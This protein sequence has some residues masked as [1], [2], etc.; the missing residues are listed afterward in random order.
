M[1]KSLIG[2]SAFA[3]VALAVPANSASADD[4]SPP[5]V[6]LE[7]LARYVP[8]TTMNTIY[9]ACG[10]NE[11][12]TTES[13][14]WRASDASGMCSETFTAQ[15][16]ETLGGDYDP[17]LGGDTVTYSVSPNARSQRILVDNFDAG[18][19]PNRFV[20][21]VT[22]C[23]GNTSASNIATAD[24]NVVKDNDS[25]L[26][27]AG[28]WKITHFRGFSGGSAHETTAKGASVTTTVDGGN[29]ALVMERKRDRGAVDVFV[30]GVR[31]A[32]VN[33]YSAVTKHRQVV[34]Q[35]QLR[36]G[37][38]T[39]KVINRATHGR[40]LSTLDGLLF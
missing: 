29:Y 4:G 24:I 36:D 18:R 40:P 26:H 19:V 16:Y 37:V 12:G 11:V 2:A 3:M 22:D 31:R 39:I 27:Y 15:T 30:D 5:S 1:L 32:T 38:H 23:A 33:N 28:A 10:D 20:V 34:W 35:T 21:R 14:N 6:S 25:T 7:T 8:G 17:I 13:L 9:D